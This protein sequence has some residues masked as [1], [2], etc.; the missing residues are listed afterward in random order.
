MAQSFSYELSVPGAPSEVQA[1][2]KGTVTER[3]RVA[4]S[5]RLAA[6]EAASLSFRPRWAFPVLL[7]AVRM[8]GGEN[9]KLTF[10]AA[11]GGTTVAVS[12][13]VGSSTRKLATREFWA[14]ILQAE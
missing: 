5:M 14:E 2:L 4:A 3:L 7:A 11:E 13:K 9:V 12:G 1:R 10:S 6:E 8:I